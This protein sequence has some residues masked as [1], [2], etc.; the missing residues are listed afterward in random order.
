M[1][2]ESFG[3]RQDVRQELAGNVHVFGWSGSA[4]PA[5]ESRIRAF[6]ELY[7]DPAWVLTLDAEFHRYDR[8]HPLPVYDPGSPLFEGTDPSQ[9]RVCGLARILIS[10]AA[11][12]RFIDERP[13]P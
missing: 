2:L 5:L 13:C 10:G 12:R 3:D 1:L 4:V 11:V 9:D 6:E 8:Y 7:D